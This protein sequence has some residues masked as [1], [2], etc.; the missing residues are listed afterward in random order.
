MVC[1]LIGFC[2]HFFTFGKASLFWTLFFFACL[3]SARGANIWVNST[4]L[5]GKRVKNYQV[6]GTWPIIVFCSVIL[7]IFCMKLLNWSR[8]DVLLCSL[9]GQC[10]VYCYAAE[11][12]SIRLHILRELLASP[13]GTFPASNFYLNIIYIRGKFDIVSVAGGFYP[14]CL[15]PWFM[16]RCSEEIYQSYVAVVG[17]S[18]CIS[19]Y[20]TDHQF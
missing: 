13:S 5:Q 16:L 18:A 1:T 4:K 9:T 19:Y 8:L 15:Q 11:L 12:Q 20:E 7:F 3:P 6:E 10:H 17:E 14:S 2:S